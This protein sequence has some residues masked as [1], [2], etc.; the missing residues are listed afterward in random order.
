[1]IGETIFIADC[2][3]EYQWVAMPRNIAVTVTRRVLV[4]DLSLAQPEQD[5]VI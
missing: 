5:L 2:L 1:M 4:G 3:G